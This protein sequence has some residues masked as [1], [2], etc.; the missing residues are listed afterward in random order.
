MVH[1]QE[2]N[3]NDPIC[4]SVSYNKARL[5]WINQPKL[6]NALTAEVRELLKV[7]LRHA[8]AD[9]TVG[10]IVIAGAGG[11]FCAGGDISTMKGVTAPAGRVRMQAA[12]E[13]M[14]LIVNSPKPV[15][16]A[17]EGWAVGAGLG[18]AAGCDI[19]VAGRQAKFSAPFGNLGLM[20]DLG[21]LFTLPARIGMGK[22]KLL[23]FTRRRIDAE[24]AAEWGLV[25]EVAEDGAATS[26]AVALAN[27]IAQAAPLSNAYTKQLLARLPLSFSEFLSAEND[28]QAILFS[29]EDLKEGA[30]A[31]FEKRTPDFKGR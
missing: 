1:V 23:A 18:L 17:V 9:D 31:F 16:A 6:R 4:S 28:S 21:S 30:A 27:E 8:I 26:H 13:L 20:P 11:S 15:I 22:T 7:E 5:I 29:S 3:E 19:V 14:Q 24:C 2:P 10:A 12:A 25:D